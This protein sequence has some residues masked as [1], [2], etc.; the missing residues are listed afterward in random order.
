MK[1]FKRLIPH[2]I[3]GIISVILFWASTITTNLEVKD[4]LINIFSNAVFFFVA[5][6]FYDSIRQIIIN[7]EKKYLTNY[8][9]NKI[10]NDIFVALYFVK[11]II[12]GYNLDTNTLKNIFSIINY[13][14]NE[15]TNS[16]KHQNYLGFQ[17]LKDLDEVRSLFKSAAND[18]FILKYS[19]HID[20]ISIVRMANN[21]IKLEIILKNEN[22]FNKCAENAIEYIIMNGKNINPE[23]DDKYLLLKRVQQKNRFVV[24]DSGYFEEQNIDKLLNS[25]V[26]KEDVAE[27]IAKLL[28]ETFLLMKHWV[29]EV[30]Q[31]SKREGR[32]RIIKDFFNP[33][34]NTKTKD[35]KIYVADIVDLK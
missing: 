21:L 6:L 2:L 14:K 11:K 30:I 9:K 10:A 33:N 12:H 27:K 25:Y 20:M 24:Y 26:L 16:I 15:I 34:T 28:L 1:N 3:L 5:Y 23:N 19:S 7:K 13:S 17:I 22:N 31:L 35:T 4:I 18:N 32:F 8:I 29:P